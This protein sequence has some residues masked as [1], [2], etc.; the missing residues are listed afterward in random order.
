MRLLSIIVFTVVLISNTFGQT[1]PTTQVKTIDD[2]VALRIPTINNRLSAL[3]TGRVTENDG[4]GGVF[5]YEA[6]SA[7]STNLGTVF[8]PAASAG[9]WLRQY[10]GALNVKWFGAVGDGVTDDTVEIQNALDTLGYGE[11][12]Y[13]PSTGD[14]ATWYTASSALLI[15]NPSGK[16][17]SGDGRKASQIRQTGAGLD[18]FTFTQGS[19]GFTIRDLWMEGGGVARYGLNYLQVSRSQILN[20]RFGSFTAG[21]FLDGAIIVNIHGCEFD[22]N[23][24]GILETA[25]VISGPNGFSVV[26]NIFENQ[27]NYGLNLYQ[28]TG[29]S[30][31]GNTVESNLKGGF[32]MGTAGGRGLDISGNYFEENTGSSTNAFDIYVGADSYASGTKIQANYFNGSLNDTNYFPIRIKYS[33]G[34]TI[35]R[36]SLTGGSRFV[37]FAT[38]AVVDNSIFG[39]LTFVSG[40]PDNTDGVNATYANIPSN[41]LT[42]DNRITDQF[43]YLNNRENMLKGDF[44]YG[45]WSSLVV[46]PNTWTRAPN[47]GTAPDSHNGRP[48]GI[49]SKSSVND[50]RILQTLTVSSTVNSFVRGNWASF[51][52]DIYTASALGINLTLDDAGS[53]GVTSSVTTGVGVWSTYYVSSYFDATTTS[54]RVILDPQN[55]GDFYLANPR[56][57]VG[58]DPEQIQGNQSPYF[59][60]YSAAPTDG[61]W[62]VGDTVYN[63]TVAAA[64]NLGWV[65]TT[66]GTP[67]TWTSFGPVETPISPANGGTGTA[68]AFTAGSVVFAGASGIYDQSNTNLFWDNSAKRLG[69]GTAVPNRPIEIFDNSNGGQ[70]VLSRDNG[71]TR[72]SL[73]FARN[74]AGAAQ[75]TSTIEGNSDSASINSGNLVFYATDGAGSNVGRAQIDSA[76]LSI[77]LSGRLRINEGANGGMGV[78][79]L[80]GGTVTV[81]NTAVTASTRIFVSRSTTGGTEGHLSTTQIAGTSFTVN[82]SSGTDTSTVNWLLILP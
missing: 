63:S 2:L 76:G 54:L 72:G 14:S 12:L 35:D 27:S 79:T 67:G 13:F 18:L 26:G 4:G 68:T 36:N 15:T 17:I 48:V 43:I 74:N 1:T 77:L 80:V 42:S 22:G 33:H 81:A 73:V 37:H 38:S 32:W 3:V 78:A 8:K 71:T 62:A 28:L 20:C 59:F 7:V 56:V 23:T 5:F 31:T 39:P 45:G 50:D 65:C 9:R 11:E 55:N 25:S 57:F 44:P 58:L 53:Q 29:W 24:D 47:T 51:A 41:F 46:G 40:A 69:I 21:I 70:L 34:V 16:I 82:S 64:S 61:T 19:S 52:I 49:I 30:F 6:A 66:A 75:I 10:S 60:T